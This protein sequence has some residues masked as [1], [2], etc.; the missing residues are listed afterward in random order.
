MANNKSNSDRRKLVWDKT[1]GICAH[2]G[3]TASNRSRTI[4]HYVPRSAGGGY[5]MR[6]LMPLCK[7]CNIRREN[8]DIDPYRFYKYAPKDALDQ[9]I[10][11][12]KEFNAGRRSM[13][14]QTY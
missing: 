1:G 14:G 7:E 4:D 9:C 5:D 2:C 11:Y 12:E 3:R 6:N 10:E 8:Y 13:G